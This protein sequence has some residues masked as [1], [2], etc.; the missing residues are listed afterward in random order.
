MPRKPC[1]Q[2]P[3]TPFT[4][5]H[6]APLGVTRSMIHTAAAS[7]RITRLAHGVYI[8][9]AAVAEDPA[10]HHLQLALAHQL[11][12]PLA[13]AS[14]H[15]AALAWGLELDDATACATSRPTYIQPGESGNRS[16]QSGPIRLHVRR[17]P[18]HQRTTHPTGL[19]VTTPARAAVDMSAELAFPAA[20]ITL[21][22]A[23]RLQ[24][25]SQVGVR[26][27]R[28][29]YVRATS[30]AAAR[31]PLSDAADTA[32]TLR[33]RRHL[34]SVVAWADPR[35]ETPLESYSFGQMLIAG[36]PVPDLQVCI[37]SPIGDLYPDFLWQEQAV[38]GEADGML[39]Y[40]SPDTLVR[41]K[42]RQ[43]QLERMG[44]RVVRWD[45]R[46]IRRRPAAVIQ[47]ITSALEERGQ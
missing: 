3:E 35:R 40:T 21:D 12:H 43:E 27:M 41:E 14:H 15:T 32:A 37:S 36:L 24:M 34:E 38:I 20:L 9:T 11:V 42:Q 28:A 47:R 1:W 17:L 26:A 13:I 19:L 25:Q 6:V 31:R 22:S 44:F 8:A 45:Y 4:W 7:G 39:K 33:T 2:P 5:A 16:R 29:H 46:E 18:A 30:L 10:Q 23:A